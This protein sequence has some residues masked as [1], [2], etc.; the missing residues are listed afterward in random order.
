VGKELIFDAT[1][2]RANA[3]LDSVVP[4]LKEVVDDHLVELFTSDGA[5][6]KLTPSTGESS[7][8]SAR[9]GARRYREHGRGYS[10]ALEPPG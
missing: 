10:V 3:A 9:L 5:A 1:K 8:T 2:V 7:G 4:R 6:A